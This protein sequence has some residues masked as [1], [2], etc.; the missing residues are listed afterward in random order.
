[1]Y[2]CF[3]KIVLEIRQSSFNGHSKTQ[4]KSKAPK[5]KLRELSLFNGG[6]ATRIGGR[7]T[8]FFMQVWGGSGFF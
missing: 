8:A 2:T 3:K 5:F 7:A 4:I 1:M 6:R